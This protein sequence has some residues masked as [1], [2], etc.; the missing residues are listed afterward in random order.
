MRASSSVILH[1]DII[2]ALRDGVPF[3]LAS[4]GAVLTSGRGETGILPLDY[5]IR[6]EEGRT[7]ATIWERGPRT[8]Q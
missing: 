8:G 3:Q 2:S 1:I 6:A 5:V 7:G 4:N